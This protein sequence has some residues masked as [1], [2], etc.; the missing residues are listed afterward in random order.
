MTPDGSLWQPPGTVNRAIL[1]L[2]LA[3]VSGGLSGCLEPYQPPPAIESAS[4][5]RGLFDPKQG[6][7]AVTLSEPVSPETLSVV[8]RTDRR[9]R[10]GQLCVEGALGPGCREASETVLGPCAADLKSAERSGDGLRFP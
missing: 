10:E 4:L 6:P 7:L 2:A 5:E 9:D 3:L 8:L 1:V